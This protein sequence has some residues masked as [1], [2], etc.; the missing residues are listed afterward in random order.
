MFWFLAIIPLGYLVGAIVNYLSDFLPSER[1][2]V[3]PYCLGCRKPVGIASYLLKPVNCTN[4]GR[5]RGVRTLIVYAAYILLVGFIWQFPSPDYSSLQSV[6]VCIY[7]GIVI[8]VDFEHRLIL[9][10]VSVAGVLIALWMGIPQHGL[11]ATLVGGAVGFL[12]M[13]LLY[14]GGRLFIRLL[15]KRRNYADVDEALGFGDVI[16]A[17]I[18]G[19]MLGWPGIIAGLVLAIIL[20]G[21]ISLLYLLVLFL[22]H[23]YQ[24]NVTIAYGPYL[25]AS[26]FLLLFLKDI[27]LTI[28]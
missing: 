11:I 26:A 17:G 16:L 20:A 7:F 15:K 24:S 28:F 23:R 9:H 25:V 13:Y 4:C 22:S 21:I 5:K 2:I 6:L 8:V 10:P 27:I 18:I 12:M 14:E 19:L 1:K 3:L